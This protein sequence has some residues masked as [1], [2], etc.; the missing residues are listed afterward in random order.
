MRIDRLGAEAAFN[1]SLAPR[2]DDDDQRRSFEGSAAIGVNL[3]GATFSRLRL[4]GGY[5]W[6]RHRFADVDGSPDS[7]SE[8]AI[9]AS[10]WP[11]DA[12]PVASRASRRGST[13]HR[14]QRA[15]RTFGS[16]PAWATR[17]SYQSLKTK[18]LTWRESWALAEASAACRRTRAFLAEAHPEIFSTTVSIRAG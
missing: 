14:R 17:K 12:W 13:V 11:M 8:N 18:P 5:R 16:P 15:T 6:T 9:Q 7:L 10:F 1:A 2:G 3:Y 4:G